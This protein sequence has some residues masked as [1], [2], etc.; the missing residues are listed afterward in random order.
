MISRMRL[1]GVCRGGVRPRRAAFPADERDTASF[2]IDEGWYRS[3]AI[4]ELTPENLLDELARIEPL[5]TDPLDRLAGIL[6]QHL[7]ELF[8]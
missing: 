4:A 8:T 1:S 3:L 7:P 6:R 2:L 5:A